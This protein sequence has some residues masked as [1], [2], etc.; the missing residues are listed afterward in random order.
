MAWMTSAVA[1]VIGAVGMLNTMV[2]SVFERTREIGIL[3]AIGWRRSR[4]V[5]MILMES[6]LLSIGGGVIGTVSAVLLIRFLSSTPSVSGLI[7]GNIP[8]TVMGQGFLIALLVGLIGAAYP[9][10]RGAQLL[11]TEAIRHE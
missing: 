2:M 4:V 10:Y 7:S 6:I 3:R 11:P 8:W 1:V 5:R 9:A